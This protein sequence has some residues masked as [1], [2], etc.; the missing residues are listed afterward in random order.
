M[1]IHVKLAKYWHI[2]SLYFARV[3]TSIFNAY[4]RLKFVCKETI[5]KV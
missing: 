2:K 3:K 1:D 5:S 4:G